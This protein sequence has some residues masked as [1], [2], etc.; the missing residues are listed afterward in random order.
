MP[1]T[2]RRSKSHEVTK[3]EIHHITPKGRE[4]PGSFEDMVRSMEYCMY[5]GDLCCLCRL[6][7][8]D[9]TLCFMCYEQEQAE[10]E[11]Y[12]KAKAEETP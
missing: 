6:A 10:E 1:S 7:E 8:D 5:C 3:L 11:A 12:E 4:C 2:R 9:P